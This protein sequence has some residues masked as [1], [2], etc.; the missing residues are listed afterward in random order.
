MTARTFL[1]LFESD[2]PETLLLN[3]SALNTVLDIIGL[4]PGVGEVADLAN[5]A[6]YLK[7]VSNGENAKMNTLLAALSLVSVFPAVGDVIGKG[8][9]VL[10]AAAKGGKLGKV[11]GKTAPFMIK[12]QK[13][14][15]QNAGKI[16]G[17]FNALADKDNALKAYIPAMRKALTQ[18]ASGDL[19]GDDTPASARVGGV[20]T[21]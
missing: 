6:L 14:I 20:Q 18:F 10:I 16:D 8:G 19:G 11:G 17:V 21:A 7:K 4:V 3:E 13:T 2:R 5:T 15:A 12:V 9:K 1:A